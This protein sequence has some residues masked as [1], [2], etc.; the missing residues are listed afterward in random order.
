VFDRLVDVDG[1]R[2]HVRCV[3][4]GDTTVLLIAGFESGD[5]NWGKVQPDLEARARVCSY[6][7]AG[8]GTSDPATS[9]QTFA[10]QATILRNLL[11]KVGE[12]G[13]YVVVGHSFGGAE[14]ITFASLFADE[15][16][17]VVL[18]DASPTTW[19]T[20]L[21]AIADDG[22]ETASLFRANCTGWADPTGNRE[23]L[24][25]F[26]AF[27]EVDRIG[28]L[29]SLPIAVITA[30]ARQFA[31]LSATELARLTRAWDQGQQRW[32][33]L[34]PAARLVSVED[35]SHHIELDRPDVVIKAIVELL[36]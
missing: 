24:D 6:A 4:R 18:I 33:A 32:T 35:T 9:T 29:G 8:T 10:T 23:H 27:A 15:V 26:A 7:R 20:E 19:P 22:S 28:S 34:S 21:C 1:A 30:A 11:A 14:A 36:P 3:G 25:V 13:P 2:L 17:G 5:D 16:A 12:S 31:G